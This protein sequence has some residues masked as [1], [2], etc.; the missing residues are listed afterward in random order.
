V[1]TFSGISG[2]LSSLYAQR[3][4]MELA[5]QNI[6]NANTP[7]YTRQRADLQAVGGSVVP[8]MHA[9]SDFSNGGVAIAKVDRLRDQFLESRGRAEHAQGAYLEGRKQVLAQV[10]DV[11]A[12]PSDT[13]LQSQL[14]D[15]WSSWGD[16]A[17]QPGD[18]AARTQLLQ[19]GAV[20]ADGLGAAHNGLTSQWNTIRVQAD[21]HLSDIN[22]NAA[23]VAQLNQAIVRGTAVGMPVNELMDQ[24]DVHLIKLSELAGATSVIR[25]DGSAHVFLEGSALVNGSAARTVKLTGAT[26]MVDQAGDKVR[27]RWTD[28]DSQVASGGT[29]GAT[30]EALGDTIPGYATKLDTIATRL[31]DTVNTVHV[32]GYGL[33]GV[34]DRNFFTTDP[35][36]APMGAT[37]IAVAITDPRQVGASTAPGGGLDASN[38]DALARLAGVAGGADSTYRE[39]VVG[40]GV[41]T[42]AAGRR[43]DIQTTVTNS[44][45]AS[46]MAES[47]VNLDEEMTN[48]LSFQRAYE[49]ASR[50]LTTLDGM[51]DTLINRTGLVG[52]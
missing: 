27:L 42:Q 12:E 18:A 33:D 23:A 30:I 48:M 45:D 3:R 14:A 36:G 32:N 26:R 1:S 38:A 2:A 39:M 5:G 11:F 44:V 21:G 50:M 47:G 22:E 29:M 46:R 9:V 15:F 6:A 17:N 8:A 16:V 10:E 37:T 19:R 51:L 43:A 52:R 25:P 13:A 40:L 20:A 31:A 28:N 7:G 41:A 35:A 4:G 34:K 49:A 24:R